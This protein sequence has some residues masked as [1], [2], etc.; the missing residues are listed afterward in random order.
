[1]RSIAR[2]A[3]V[4]NQ[5]VAELLNDSGGL[6]GLNVFVVLA[7]QDALASLHTHD[8]TGTLR[9]KNKKRKKKISQKL[10]KQDENARNGTAMQSQASQ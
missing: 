6:T 3:A 4:L 9:V 7:N 1:V 2:L 5:V 10:R 8:T